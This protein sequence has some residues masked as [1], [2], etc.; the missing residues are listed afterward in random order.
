MDE[1]LKREFDRYDFVVE[2][3]KRYFGEWDICDPVVW[4]IIRLVQA[5]NDLAHAISETS[6][7]YDNNA[8]QRMVEAAI[9]ERRKAIAALLRAFER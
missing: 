8:P 9:A 4:A 3:A 7:A 5:Q 6:Y 2:D 1:E